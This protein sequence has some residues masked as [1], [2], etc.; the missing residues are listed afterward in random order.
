VHLGIE[1]SVAEHGIFQAHTLHAPHL[2]CYHHLAVHCHPFSRRFRQ[3]V[4]EPLADHFS[5]IN[6]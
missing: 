4:A 2:S 6:V 1:G 5:A 3:F